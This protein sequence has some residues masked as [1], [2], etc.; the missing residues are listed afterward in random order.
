MGGDL[1]KA[2]GDAPVFMVYALRDPVGANLDRIQIVKGWL[3]KKGNTHEKV[4]DV[5][6]SDNRI[7]GAD[8][9]LP[10]VGNTVDL[11]AANWTNTIGA[12]E[13]AAVWTDPDFDPKLKAFYYTRVIEI[14][15]PRWI[16]Y[17]KVRLGAEIPEGAKLIHQERGY[18][19]PIWYTP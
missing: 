13:L 16:L 15:T 7:P 14:P 5:A 11:E 17:D 9:K 6:W 3:D 12:S 2:A 10:A 8:G 1:P 4:Y 19:S 18:S